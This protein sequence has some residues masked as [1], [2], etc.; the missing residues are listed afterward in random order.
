L[1]A[2]RSLR[3]EIIEDDWVRKVLPA[4][5]NNAHKGTFG[6]ALVVAGS[7]NYTGAALLSGQAA[8]RVGAGLVTLAVPERCTRPWQGSSRSHLLI[9]PDAVGVI[10]EEAAEVRLEK[11]RTRH[12]HVIGP[13]FGLEEPTAAFLSQLLTRQH[14]PGAGK[15]G[16][17]RT[18]KK[19]RRKSKLRCHHCVVDADG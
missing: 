1:Q 10:A 13:G 17:I 5:P 8:Y 11:C 9:L 4:R 19:P 7:V 18:E 6:T 15:I 16:F 2:W 12:S 14:K 3:C